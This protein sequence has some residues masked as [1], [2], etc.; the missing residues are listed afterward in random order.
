MPKRL[1]RDNESVNRRATAARLLA[2]ACPHF[3]QATLAELI[4]VSRGQLANY[5]R[6]SVKCRV[7]DNP[8]QRRLWSAAAAL[9]FGDMKAAARDFRTVADIL[10][11]L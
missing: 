2:L 3:S 5:L 7:T 8:W 9:A 1:P 6:G 4:G 10:E 11:N